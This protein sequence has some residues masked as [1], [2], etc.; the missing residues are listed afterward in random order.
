MFVTSTDGTDNVIVWAAGGGGDQR[1]HAYDSD[2]GMV[3]YSGGGP[4]EIMTGTRRWNTGIVARGRI[5]YPA[6][7]KIYAFVTPGRVPTPKPTPTPTATP[8]PSVSPMPT[9]RATLRPRPIPR[10]RPTPPT[11]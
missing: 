7:N 9:P 5:Y 8:S 6:N 10:S 2:T 11:P 3:I 1:L 4:D